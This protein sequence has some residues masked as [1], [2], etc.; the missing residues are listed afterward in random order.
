[1]LKDMRTLISQDLLN[2]FA[3]CNSCQ[4]LS[5]GGDITNIVRYMGKMMVVSGTVSQHHNC[6]SATMFTIVPYA[7]Y[8]GKS[9]P[10]TYN[11]CEELISTGKRERGYGGLIIKYKSLRYVM[12][13]EI[14]FEP[15]PTLNNG[16][17]LD[18]FLQ[19]ES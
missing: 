3:R 19:Y 4:Q 2:E 18:L 5:E 1:M 10:L 16:K 8:K 11:Q 13:E 6:V 7:D 14:L 17:Q 15:D 9:V 12:C